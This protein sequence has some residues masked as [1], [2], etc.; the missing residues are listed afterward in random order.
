MA[1]CSAE[2]A[3]KAYLKTLKMAQKANKPDVIEFIST[4]VAGNNAKLMVVAC[5]GA[6]DSKTLALAAAFQYFPP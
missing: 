4:L 1:C 5:A 6:A 3:T 2:N